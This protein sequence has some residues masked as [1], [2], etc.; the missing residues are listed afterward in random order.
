M[1]PGWPTPKFDALRSMFVSNVSSDD[2]ELVASLKRP[3]RQ[4]YGSVEFVH[5]L[6]LAELLPYA[7]FA[8]V[9]RLGLYGADFEAKFRLCGVYNQT[10]YANQDSRGWH[11]QN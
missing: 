4:A 10:S 5:Y 8:K 2:Q 1:I 7:K 3:Q 11:T 6:N 9:E